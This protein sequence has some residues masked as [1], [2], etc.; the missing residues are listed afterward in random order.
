MSNKIT[1][2]Q[3]NTNKVRTYILES[4]FSTF[5]DQ[6]FKELIS[7]QEMIPT[8]SIRFSN[9]KKDIHGQEMM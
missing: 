3:V 2:H 5:T 1:V 9:L 4:D 8:K 6:T 7:Q